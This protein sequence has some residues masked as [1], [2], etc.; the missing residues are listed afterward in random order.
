MRLALS[1]EAA[2][3]AR[4]LMSISHDLKTP[5]TSVRGY[6]EA[7]RDGHADDPEHRE[8]YLA[9]IEDKAMMLESRIREMINY[10]SLSTG[11]WQVTL[12]PVDLGQF[13]STIA[14]AFEE[15]AR[16]FRRSFMARLSIPGGTMAM[17]DEHL[18]TRS[19]ENL[20]S[21]SLKYSS[22]GGQIAM[23]GYSLG[24]ATELIFS[25]NGP[26]ISNADVS[27]VFEP[28]YRGAGA[29]ST[30]GMG[31]GLSIVK[32]IM[33]AHGFSIAVATE[34]SAGA[35]ITIRIPALAQK[36]P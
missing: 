11:D 8:R 27:R 22:E 9:I 12:R 5:L 19:L 1:E 16:V 33:D 4:F 32:S 26:G 23:S 25:D 34:Q 6:L 10:V 21:N 18:F 14:A 2:R 3:R 13:L 31:L 15:E 30:A 17:L 29:Q 24:D 7:L 28:L 20:F 36:A 35:V